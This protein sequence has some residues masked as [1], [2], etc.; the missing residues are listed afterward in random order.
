[1][2]G[3]AAFALPSPSTSR[4]HLGLPADRVFPTSDELSYETPFE[5]SVG[6]EDIWAG[7]GNVEGFAWMGLGF[8][9]GGA[10]AGPST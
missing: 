7:V 1:M 10:A 5:I 9:E 8:E 2:H 4:N 3:Q 6:E